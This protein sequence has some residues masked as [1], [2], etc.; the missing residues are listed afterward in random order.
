MF[1]PRRAFRAR[2]LTALS[3]LTAVS[4]M[5]CVTFAIRAEA[6]QSGA[7][8][9][10]VVDQLGG[11][12]AGAK[13]TLTRDGQ[14]VADATSDAE[15]R[16]TL[17]VSEA[18]R[19]G[20][21]VA[22]QGFSLAHVDAFFVP[23]G[24]RVPVR[25]ALSVGIEQAVVVTA[26]AESLPASQAG[27]S[28]TVIDRSVIDGL[29]TPDV[30]SAIRLVPGV[31]IVQ[32]G[33]RGGGTSLFV[34]G[35]ESRFNKVLIDGVP[36][37]DIG[38]LFDFADLDTTG[39]GRVEVS[40]NANSVLFGDDA[41]AGVVALTTERG[42]TPTPQVTYAID[43]GTLGTQRHDVT[44]GGATNRIDYFAA[45]SFFDTDNDVA[46]SAYRRNS[47]ATRLGIAASASTDITAVFRAGNG[48][49]GLPNATAFYG[50][51]DDT[52]QKQDAQLFSLTAESRVSSRLRTT[53]RYALLH[54]DYHTSNPSPTGEYVDPFGFG[55]NYLGDDVTIEGANGYSVTGRSI[56]DY[57]SSTYP[58]KYDA[59]TTRH[60]VSGQATYQVQQA[61]SVSAGVRFEREDGTTNSGTPLSSTRNN[62]GAFVEAQAAQGPVSV[63]AGVGFDHNA[64]FGFAATPRVS[65][66]AYLR[67]P[68]ASAPLGDTR[69][70]FN[71]SR[72]IKAPTVY[73]E[74]QSLYV[75]VDGAVPGVGP[76]GPERGSGFDVGVEQAFAGG[77]VRA[78][79]TYFHNTFSDLLEYVSSSVLP[80][81]G[82][83]PEAA[84]ASGYG[85]YVN[86]SSYRAQGLE[87]S[88]DAAIGRLTL[89]AS[90][91][92]LD[93]VVTKSLSDGVLSPAINPAFPDI[94]IGQYAP[95]V[96][97]RPFRRPTHSGSLLARYTQDKL[98]IAL[99]GYFSGKADES[100][101]LSDAEFGYSML[102]PN[103]DLSA[104]FQKI[105]LS[106]SYAFH[107]RARWY[108][109]MENLLDEDYQP[110]AGF[111]A[112]PF[113]LRTGVALTIGGR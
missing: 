99:A 104:G 16:F 56:L 23:A 7:V 14:R 22:A 74:S 44:I 24:A 76:I 55:G 46:N 15:G 49:V 36:A 63:T 95:L 25:V 103:H 85:A 68:S 93:A 88:S 75:L 78:R 62:P 19:Y 51:A 106:A 35:G 11:V 79:A 59:E 69:V 48:R 90:Y 89:M 32:S 102:L 60:V 27:A 100:T 21:D 29:A 77:R 5:L 96:D 66:S 54:T 107:P 18:G 86:A 73:Q 52:T 110:A 9:G 57:G 70:L 42:H 84:A 94:P 40:R 72:G 6:A 38:G 20:V 80:Q 65:A 30:A 8:T 4:L 64:T 53:V 43:G 98:Q 45:Y 82:V 111:P 92:F 3:L 105:D 61:L 109:A 37:N 31:N 71:A 97:A 17:A 13:V 39:V 112:L 1:G 47:F 50:L 91:T 113:T 28:V 26:A 34:R 2:S 108:L 101:Y 10:V 12:V 58:Q 87:L 41:L 67:K 33:N 83:S 81:L